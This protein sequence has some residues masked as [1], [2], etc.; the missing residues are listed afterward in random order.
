[1]PKGRYTMFLSLA[2]AV[3]PKRVKVD[4]FIGWMGRDGTDGI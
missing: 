1:M 2:F 4:P 3:Q